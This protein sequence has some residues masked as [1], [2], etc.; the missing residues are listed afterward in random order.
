MKSFRGGIHPPPN[1]QSSLTN[2]IK[3]AGLPDTV[4]IPLSQHIG[5]PAKV[6]VKVGEKVKVG[7]P[8]GEP[9]GFISSFIH[10][11]ISGTVKKIDVF[12]H[13]V[14]GKAPA[15]MIESDTMDE[16]DETIKDRRN[17]EALTPEEI[18]AIVKKAGIVGMGGAAFPTH[19][20]LSPPPSKKIDTVIIN[21][22]EC[23]PY[24]TCDHLLML[25]NPLEVIKGAQ[26]IKKAVGAEK[27]YIGIEKNKMDALELLFSK[28]RS[29]NVPDMKPLPLPVKYPQ[30]AEKQLIH[31]M[32]DREVPLGGLPMDVGVV[33]Q[34]V[35]TAAAVYEA[36]YH[37]KPLY[38]RLVTLDG[39]SLKKSQNIKIRIGSA[40][41]DAVKSVGGLLNQPR[42]IIMGGPM[43]GLAQESLDVPV[44][45]ATSGILALA[46]YEFTD[47]P[48]RPCIRCG[49][50]VSVCPMGLTPNMVTL[51]GES[52]RYEWAESLGARDCIECGSCSYVCPAKRPMVHSVKIVKN[53]LFRRER[54]EKEKQKK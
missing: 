29:H 28:I 53:E 20:K 9:D 26:L 51:A 31:A 24:L 1:K 50:C 22:A 46:A 32:L 11:S 7:T 39:G 3:Y 16:R 2:P 43:M 15:V 41:R 6:C 25:F 8:I 17:V 52:E 13:P 33:V 48:T 40:F 37:G 23:E 44:V 38:E 5:S 35:A 14:L 45:K 47:S 18:I 49:R 4:I 12:P 19:V 27:C 34:N 30:G 21:G 36:V 54:R 10:S 42:R